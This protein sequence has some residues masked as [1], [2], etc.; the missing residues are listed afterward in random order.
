[1]IPSLTAGQSIGIWLQLT[2]PDTESYDAD[3]FARLKAIGDEASGF[4]D[5]HHTRVA[6][7]ATGICWEYT[8]NKTDF[9]RVLFDNSVDSDY[10][11]GEF[12]VTYS[13][14]VN[15]E[16]IV[17]LSETKGDV[18]VRNIDSIFEI[19]VFVI[20]YSG[21]VIDLTRDVTGKSAIINFSARNANVFDVQR[22]ELF[23][24]NQTGTLT[25]EV[26]GDIDALTGYG[27]GK[28]IMKSELVD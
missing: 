18:F 20:P 6:E 15:K 11:L 9:V 28:H 21:F 1:M 25:A 12:G 5:I 13:I 16:Q 7:M 14:I 8:R 22:F 2:I 4:V 26:V 27:G 23:T 24:D 17:E 10:Y 19:E 3:D